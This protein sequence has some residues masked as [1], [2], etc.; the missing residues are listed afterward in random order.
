[1]NNIGIVVIGRNEGERLRRCFQSVCRESSC[2]VYVDS[3]STDCSV[4]HAKEIAIP[5]VKLDMSNSFSAGRARNAG[6]DFIIKH[7][8]AVQYVQ[9]IDGDCELFPKW[10]AFAKDHL[11]RHKD[12]AVVAGRRKERYPEQSIYNMLCDIEWNTPLGETLSCGGDFMI[13][14][15]AFQ[16]V[17]GFNPIVIAGEEPELCYRLRQNHWKIHRLNHLMTFHDVSITK[18]SQWWKRSMRSGYAYAQGVALHG[19][20]KERFCLRDS[21]RIWFWALI[22]PLIIVL[23]SWLLNISFLLLCLIYIILIF[24]ITV[25]FAKHKQLHLKNAILYALYNITGKFSQLV[26]QIVFINRV[27]RKKD[28]KIIE[29]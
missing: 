6:F 9:F 12:W 10:L 4:A 20:E 8:L 5:V 17:G 28:N 22:F 29:Y 14:I 7:Y 26:G 2:I 24:K 13:R 18:F 23:S 25:A 11:E 16:Q 3:G 19:F 21:L 27:V 1:M 15:E